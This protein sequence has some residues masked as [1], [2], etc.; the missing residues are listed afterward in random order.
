MA[1]GDCENAFQAAA[2]ADGIVLVRARVPWINQRG[3]L[4]LPEQAAPVLPVLN[5][6]FEALGGIEVEQAAKKLT[7]LPGD[8]LHVESGVFVETDEHQHFTSHRLLTLHHY[9]DDAALGFNLD[10]YKALCEMWA[11]KADRFRATKPAIGFGLGGRQRQRAFNDALRDL[12]TPLMGHP[13]LI[14]VPAPDRDGVAAYA[15]VRD[16]LHEAVGA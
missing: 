15:R 11:P 7:V 1:R 6:I 8:F 9:P 16:R 2:A 13:P 12:V 10:E 4:G 14:R 3:H 5:V